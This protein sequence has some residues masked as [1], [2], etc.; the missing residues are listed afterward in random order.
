MWDPCV[1]LSIRFFSGEQFVGSVQAAPPRA[2]LAGQAAGAAPRGWP[3]GLPAGA[4][5]AAQGRQAA[6]LGKTAALGAV[7]GKKHVRSNHEKKNVWVV[8]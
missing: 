5:H 4:D 3:L 6:L 7:A 2:G 8:E 1:I